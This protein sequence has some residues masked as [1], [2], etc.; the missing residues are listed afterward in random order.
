VRDEVWKRDKGRCAFVAP[1]GRRCN[2][3]WD[4]EIDHIVPV[5]RGGGNEPGNLRLLCARHNRL[6]AE[7]EFGEKHMA[8][9]RGT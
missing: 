2:S 3:R 9:F 5:A 7:R 8:R 1:G 4:L 6:E